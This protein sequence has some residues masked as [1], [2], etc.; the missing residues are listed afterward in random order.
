M[1]TGALIRG[2]LLFVAFIPLVTLHEFAHAWVA[3]RCGDDTPRLQGRVTL[4]PLAH[5]D[6]IGTIVL[7]LIMT[8]LGAFGG[9]PL[10][11]GWGRPVQVNPNN[12]NRRRLDDILVSA[13][14]P[15]MNLVIGFW[16]IALM[17]IMDVSGGG[18]HVNDVL[19]VI[20]LSIFL[21]FFNLLPV[22]PLDG[23]HIM[24]NLLNISDEVYQTM[25]QYSFMF[26]VIIFR[27]PAIGGLVTEI[28]DWTLDWFSRPFGW[29]YSVS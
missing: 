5:I 10:L 19:P 9:N 1:D 21:C 6:L 25:S 4:D 3:T 23:G 17:K 15:A 28:T 22:P 26:L 18:D 2:L 24:R 7:P 29:H 13:A 11:F 16:L 27:I 8:V 14:G 20:R 12:F